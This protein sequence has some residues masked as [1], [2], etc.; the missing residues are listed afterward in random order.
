VVQQDSTPY[1]LVFNIGD[2]RVYRCIAGLFT[3]P[4]CTA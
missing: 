4:G 2:S 3:Q 1:W